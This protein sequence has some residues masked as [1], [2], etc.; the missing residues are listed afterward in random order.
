MKFIKT[1]LK[2]E[3]GQAVSEYALI[4]GLI[5]IAAIG[6]FSLIGDE[7]KKIFNNLLNA[8]KGTS[9]TPSGS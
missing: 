1:L 2:D 3:S 5:L 9:S 6:A 4:V 8:L 7:I